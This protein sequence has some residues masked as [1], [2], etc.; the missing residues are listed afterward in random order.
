MD[1]QTIAR[2]RSKIEKQTKVTSPHVSTPC[3][4]WKGGTIGPYG[5]FYWKRETE[6]A[7]RLAFRLWVGPLTPGLHVCHRCDT[8]LCVNPDHLFGGTNEDNH[9]D[10]IRKGRQAKGEAASGG[11][12]GTG[13]VTSDLARA[14]RL[15]AD[16]GVRQADIARATGIHR[17]TVSL[18]VRGKVWRYAGGPIGKR[19]HAP[20]AKARGVRH[21]GSKLD[22]AKVREIRRRFAEGES[23]TSI[24]RSIGVVAE[25]VRS[26]ARRKTWKHVP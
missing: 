12:K 16:V 7:H 10:K 4:L 3:W 15:A 8:P 17:S 26:V 19:Q 9:R 20:R 11:R 22:P 25:T 18:I 14:V 13:T 2:F 6:R 5:R 24:G 1:E 23:A 21:G